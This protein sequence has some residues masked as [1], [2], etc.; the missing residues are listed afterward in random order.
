[1]IDYYTVND[2]V[3][4]LTNN[5]FLSD[6][7]T[8]KQTGLFYSDLCRSVKDRFDN[9][10]KQIRDKLFIFSGIVDKVKKLVGTSKSCPGLVICYGTKNYAEFIVAGNQQEYDRLSGERVV[11]KQEKMTEDSIFDLASV[12]KFFT[13]L[14]LFK[15]FENGL[16]DFEQPV[17]EYDKRFKNIGHL[18][19]GDLMGFQQKLVTS[20]RIDLMSNPKEA[21]KVLF[22]IRDY[23]NDLRP[24]SDMGAIVLKY[25]IESITQM[26]F[27]DIIRDFILI[28]NR[29]KNTNIT[30]SK[31]DLKTVVS[32]NFELRISNDKIVLDM[33]TDKGIVH[34][35]KARL[36]GRNGRD[37]VGHA[38]LFSSATD[39]CLLLQ[40]ILREKIVCKNSLLK[41]SEKQIGYQ[42]AEGK[43][44]QYLG[45]LCHTKHPIEIQSEVYRNLSDAAF[46]QGGYTGTYFS[47][48]PLNGVFVF[49]GTNR[50]HHR[51]TVI[52]DCT[53]SLVNKYKETY[54]IST[55][56]AWER[57]A[58][59]HCALNLSLQYQYLEELDNQ[60]LYQSQK[61]Y[62]L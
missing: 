11:L 47:V 60:E 32:N 35:R 38:G 13:C 41:I 26:S 30:Y 54:P 42:N 4:T 25:I 7:V 1:M 46:G 21:E 20:D 53:D 3:I 31:N 2:K 27:F 34:D 62:Y 43:Y 44:S 15:L 18:T 12:T 50:C 33:D 36:L 37:L 57:D 45:M 51:T 29:M 19:V 48:D 17:G 49:L 5:L 6:D 55:K 61:V 23:P 59:C 56:F 8:K 58:L 9:G 28:P 52:H 14:T 22:A 40:N 39:M 10:Q 16:I 24:Y